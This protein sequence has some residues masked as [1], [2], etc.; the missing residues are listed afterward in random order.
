MT[1]T[2]RHR[3]TAI[4]AA[5][6]AAAVGVSACSSSS[7]GGSGSA[8]KVN[9]VA[10]SVPKPAYDA[11]ETAFKATPAGQGVQFSS[12]YGASG[13]QSKAVASG[14][15]ADFVNFSTGSDLNKLVPQFV[16]ADWNGGATKG[17]IST[18]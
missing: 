14:Q 10:Y 16:A 17:I 3:T 18:S 15:S 8:K 7:N 11:L 6:I 9:I 4:A 12:S 1:I 2:R 5:V 13:A